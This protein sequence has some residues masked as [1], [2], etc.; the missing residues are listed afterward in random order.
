MSFMI[1]EHFVQRKLLLLQDPVPK[2]S[3]VEFHNLDNPSALR[4]LEISIYSEQ[5]F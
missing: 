1:R 5:S 4:R 3:A 2:L